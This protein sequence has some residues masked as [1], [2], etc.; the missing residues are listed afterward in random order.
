MLTD[1]FHMGKKSNLKVVRA[2]F[3][4]F[5]SSRLG[6]TFNMVPTWY[7]AS[8]LYYVVFIDSFAYNNS[9]YTKKLEAYMY[10]AAQ[11]EAIFETLPFSA[12]ILVIIDY[13]SCKL[14]LVWS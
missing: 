14:P 2:L 10:Y 12:T 13:L 1:K 11:S 4:M 8:L 3:S 7:F 6:N 5:S 9:N